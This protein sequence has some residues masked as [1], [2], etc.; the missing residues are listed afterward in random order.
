LGAIQGVAPS[1]R[2]EVSSID[3]R[4]VGEVEHAIA[5]F[6]RA[7]TGGLILTGT[8]SGAR[9]ELIITLAARHQLP[10]VYPFPFHVTRPCTHKTIVRQS[11]AAANDMCV[12]PRV[13]AIF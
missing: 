8:G 4:D 13:Q 1:L 2:V 6:A 7:P 11:L 3:F 5:A 9:R 10:A 12:A